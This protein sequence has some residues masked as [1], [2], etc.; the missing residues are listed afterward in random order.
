MTLTPTYGRDYKTKI[1]VLDDWNA[2]RDLLIT[3]MSCKDMGKYVSKSE[4]PAGT[5][6]SLRYDRNTKVTV[7]TV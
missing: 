5:R 4:L 6:V 1:A 3:D 2:Y 7:V